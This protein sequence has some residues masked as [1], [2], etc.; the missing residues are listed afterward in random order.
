MPIKHKKTTLI[1]LFTL[2]SC[3]IFAQDNTKNI[4]QKTLELFQNKQYQTLI[5]IGEEA[6]KSETDYFYLRYRI[7]VAYYESG[8]YRMAAYH[9]ERALL[10]NSDD[11]TTLEYLYYSYI[12]TGC[13]TDANFLTSK[14]TDNLKEKIGFK[15]KFLS[16]I[17]LESGG[18]LSNNISKNAGIDIDGNTNIYGENDMND[19][20]L[21]GHIG[22]K[23]EISHFLSIYHGF[24]HIAIDKRK[25]IRINDKNTMRN[26]TLTQKEYYIN[27]DIQLKNNLKLTPAFHFIH[28][29][30]NSFT[31]NLAGFY[32]STTLNINNYVASLALSKEYKR[33]SLSLSGTYSNLNSA[34]QMQS[35]LAITYFPFGNLDLYTNTG[36]VYFRQ[37]QAGNTESRFIFDQMIGFKA[38]P[39]LW[40]EASFTLGNLANYNEKNAFV[41][42]NI[43]DK[44]KFKAGISFIYLLSSK[45]ELSLRYQFLNRESDYI[46]NENAITII[47]NTTN[48]QNNNITG[49]IKWKF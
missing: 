42:Y 38:F 6:I 4:E 7:G 14:M 8:N 49:G 48:Y 21:Y 33:F 44:I 19:N 1:L 3:S 26:Y 45:I 2:L 20:V 47:T 22:L 28:V 36:L 31:M 15:A 10:F 41:V 27:S 12:F 40:A 35:G 16:S 24:S 39:K 17:Y 37:K 46:M 43:A 25:I 29:G 34:K 23:H 11:P 32:Q 18:S 9:L 5:N 13:T 30:A